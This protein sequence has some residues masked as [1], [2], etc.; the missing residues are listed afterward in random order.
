MTIDKTPRSAST[1]KSESRVKEWQLPSTLDTPDA[2][3]GYKFRWI[4]QYSKRI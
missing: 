3:E 4:R 1:R 2:P